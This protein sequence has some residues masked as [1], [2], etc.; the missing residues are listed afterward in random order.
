MTSRPAPDAL[1][2][3]RRWIA[4]GGTWRAGGGSD[5]VVT[6]HLL[7]CDGAEL[8]GVLSSDDPELVAFVEDHREEQ[9]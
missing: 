3:L 9:A 4:A 6:V 5:G 7:T 8:Q 2:E 1:A